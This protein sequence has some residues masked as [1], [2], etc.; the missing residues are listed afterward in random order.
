M[1]RRIR[2]G[3]GTSPRPAERSWILGLYSDG[4]Q[5]AGVRCQ[6]LVPPPH[7]VSIPTNRSPSATLTLRSFALDSTVDLLV[8]YLALYAIRM[9]DGFSTSQ[10]RAV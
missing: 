9:Q 3:H 5:P 2:G 8:F 6:L 10:N 4:D 7:A 1:G